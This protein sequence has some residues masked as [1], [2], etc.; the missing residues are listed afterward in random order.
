[1]KNIFILSFLLCSM[2]FYSCSDSEHTEKNIEMLSI[3]KF[4]VKVGNSDIEGNIDQDKKVIMVMVPNGTDLKKIFV[5]ATYTE[6]ATLEP[7]SGYSYN[8]SNPVDFILSKNGASVTYKVTVAVQPEM[9]SFEVGQYYKKAM[10][11]NDIIKIQFS[12][13]TDLTK[14]TPTIRLASGCNIEP[15]SDTEVNLSGEF[16]YTV[17]NSAGNSKLYKVQASVLP[18]EKQV[19]GVWVPDP[20]HTTVL[21]NYKNLK[22]FINLLDELNINAIYLATWVREMTLFKSSVLKNNTNYATIEDGWLLNGLNYD[23]PTNDPIKDLLALAHAK[24]MKVFFWFEYG[25]M[26]SGGESPSADHPIL[27]THPEWDGIN[28]FGKAA[29]YNSTDYYLNSYNPEVQ[30]FIISLIE[31]A[32][33]M[34]PEVDGI[35]GDDRLPAAPRNS[36]YNE[37]TKLL[38]KQQTGKEVPVN[39]EDSQ[40]VKWRLQN[41]NEFGEKMYTRI[42]NKKN[43]ILVASSPNPY[44][45]CVENLMQDWPTW[46]KKNTVDLLS[47]QCYR[48]TVSAYMNTLNEAVK[49]VKGNT[50]KNILNPGIYLRN[51]SEWE[52]VFVGQMTINRDNNTNGEAFFYNEGLKREV[53]KKV[54]KGFYTGKAIFPF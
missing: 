47:V 14:I 2:C 52:D 51:T 40:W 12:Y 8:L 29:N 18:Q 9:L 21:H 13:G 48:E 3:S 34:Y 1:M 37:S 20:S 16:S 33:D 43:T 28:S 4:L 39:Y 32:I 44:P 46:L 23:G 30:E 41:L 50:D 53:N 24:D 25:F 49:Y 19:R 38:Y 26:R 42:K 27:S 17:T 31:E 45:W 5:E 15:A 11:E 7:S 6:G 22:E 10:I 54:I 36:G 35:Q